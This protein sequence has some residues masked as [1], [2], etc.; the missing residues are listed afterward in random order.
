MIQPVTRKIIF[1]SPHM[2]RHIFFSPFFLWAGYTHFTGAL[3]VVNRN[4]RGVHLEELKFFYV[5]A[6]AI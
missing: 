2:L 4:G 6:T 1:M 5:P 3:P